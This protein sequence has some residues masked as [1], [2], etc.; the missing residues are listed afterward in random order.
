M[1]ERLQKGRQMAQTQVEETPA[2][3]KY[4]EAAQ[5]ELR[6]LLNRYLDAYRGDLQ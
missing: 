6:A 2:L 4:L 5:V 3:E 1:S